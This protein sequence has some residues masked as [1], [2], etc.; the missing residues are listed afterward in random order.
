VVDLHRRRIAL[1]A[2][3]PLLSVVPEGVDRIILADGPSLAA[4]VVRKV[5]AR[6]ADSDI[7]NEI[8]LLIDSFG[9]PVRYQHIVDVGLDAG[10]CPIEHVV[11]KP[12][13]QLDPI[14]LITRLT[15]ITAG[16]ASRLQQDNFVARLFRLQAYL[17]PGPVT[18][19]HLRSD[20]QAAVLEVER[21]FSSEHRG[22]DWVDVVAGRGHDPLAAPVFAIRARVVEVEHAGL[23]A[24]LAHPVSGKVWLNEKISILSKGCLGLPELVQVHLELP[25]VR[26]HGDLGPPKLIV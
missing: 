18:R 15:A 17:G 13:S 8:K 26:G 11:V 25:V 12:I 7:Q 24:L 5:G 9:S 4:C 20:L 14:L 10:R 3:L 1:P 21:I 6:A 22:C 2:V 16:V 19:R 23:H